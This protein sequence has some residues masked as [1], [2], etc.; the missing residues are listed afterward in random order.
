[1]PRSILLCLACKLLARKS[2]L[3]ARSRELSTASADPAAILTMTRRNGQS[4]TRPNRH[5]C[6]WLVAKTRSVQLVAMTSARAR[7]VIQALTAGRIVEKLR[8]NP[9]RLLACRKPV[10]HRSPLEKRRRP[11]A[12]Q[13]PEQA[14]LNGATNRLCFPSH[15][16]SRWQSSFSQVRKTHGISRRDSDVLS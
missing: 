1:M 6:D 8:S 15:C 4:W 14:P 3:D 7:L 11:P 9:R 2:T 5:F 10:L 13:Q 16:S 12:H